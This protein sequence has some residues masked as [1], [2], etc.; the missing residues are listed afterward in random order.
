MNVTKSYVMKPWQTGQPI[1]HHEIVDIP[2]GIRFPDDEALGRIFPGDNHSLKTWGR[3]G[4]ERTLD[5]HWIGVRKPTPMHMDPAYPRYSHHLVLRCDGM[6]LWG[7]DQERL[8]IERG[9]FFILDGHSPHQ[10][11][12]ERRPKG[13]PAPWYVAVSYDTSDAPAAPSEVIPT[14]INYALNAPLEV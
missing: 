8:P 4:D 13:S 3:A 9:S 1:L 7:W 10:L 14:L 2:T 6:W 11:C 12:S 5:P